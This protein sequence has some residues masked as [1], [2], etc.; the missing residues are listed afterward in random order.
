MLW[1]VITYA[2]LF[3]S[4]SDAIGGYSLKGGLESKELGKGLFLARH[5]FSNYPYKDSM[6]S[7]NRQ[8]PEKVVSVTGAK[9]RS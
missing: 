4:T 7:P 9:R 6:V 2:K 1:N 5:R 8:T 3:R